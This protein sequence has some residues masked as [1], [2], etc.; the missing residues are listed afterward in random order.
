MVPTGKFGIGGTLQRGK[1][2][3]R[4]GKLEKWLNRGPEYGEPVFLGIRERRYVCTSRQI[5]QQGSNQ[6]QTELPSGLPHRKRQARKAPPWAQLAI[7]DL[8]KITSKG[9]KFMSL[10]QEFRIFCG[11]RCKEGGRNV[12]IGIRFSQK[13]GL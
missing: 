10:V 3:N 13:F 7:Q 8:E 6:R 2:Q 12:N 5:Q 1:L 4:S 9:I 11:L